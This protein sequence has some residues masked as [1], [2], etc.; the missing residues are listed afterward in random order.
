MCPKKSPFIDPVRPIK[1]GETLTATGRLFQGETPVTDLSEHQV[2]F[3]IFS[4]SGELFFS[5]ASREGVHPVVLNADGS[6]TFRLSAE[7]TRTM[8]GHYHIEG[9]VTKG[10][11]VIISDTIFAFEVQKSRIGKTDKV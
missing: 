5:S 7:Q 10:N 4:Q 8:S 2:A 3:L 6:F 1:Q 9:K 11:E